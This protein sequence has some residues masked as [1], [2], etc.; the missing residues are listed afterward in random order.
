M[1]RALQRFLRYHRTEGSTAPTIS[2]HKNVIGYFRR[3]LAQACLP[4][5]LEEALTLTHARDWLDSL[6]EK[7]LAQRSLASYAQ[8]LK[9]FSRWLAEEDWLPK[10][11]LAKLKPPKYDD[12]A[13]PTF[14]IAEIETLLNACTQHNKAPL[15]GLRDRAIMLLLFSTGLRS[16]ELVGLCVED[17]DYDRGLILVRRG[18]GGKFRQVPLAG[19]AEKAID[20]YLS[21]KNRPDAAGIF[22][23]D[24]GEPL[25][26]NGLVCM[27]KRYEGWTGIHCNPHK[28]RHSAAITYLRNGGKIETLRAMLGHTTLTMTL[29]YARIA[30]VDLS[31]AHETA[32]PA[33]SLKVRV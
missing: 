29:H 8:S 12:V 28:F 18:K 21:H 20:R 30:G 5:A 17:L 7:G 32:D 24:E 14:T 9:A 26:Q 23:T 25:T 10:D 1:D 2:W 6:R 33:R 27:L 4:D 22:L 3:Y 19:K 31:A 15:L 13:K 16:A 11:P